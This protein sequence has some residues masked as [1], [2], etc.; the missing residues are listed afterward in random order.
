MNGTFNFVQLTN[1]SFSFVLIK[2]EEML[3]AERFKDTVDY[4]LEQV[5]QKS[6]GEFAP[7]L[8]WLY[9]NVNIQMPCLLIVHQSGV[10]EQD[11]GHA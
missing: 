8:L 11:I 4:I 1:T 10:N 9:A 7:I 3:M 6:I 2:G 5:E